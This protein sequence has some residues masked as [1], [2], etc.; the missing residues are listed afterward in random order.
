MLTPYYLRILKAVSQGK[1][2]RTSARISGATQGGI[3]HLLKYRY[4]DAAHSPNGDVEYTLTHLGKQELDISA[5]SKESSRED[6]LR[7]L[8]RFIEEEYL[9]GNS[10]GRDG[11]R[12]RASEYLKSKEPDTYNTCLAAFRRLD[13]LAKQ[14]EVEEKRKRISEG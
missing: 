7:A 1:V 11:I 8:G 2:K 3:N 14:N 10:M 6:Q 5:A 12:Y 13:Q 4:I 9:N